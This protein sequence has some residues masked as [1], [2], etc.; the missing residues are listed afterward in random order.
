MKA[1]ALALAG[2]IDLRCG[3]VRDAPGCENDP[4]AI[5]LAR[6]AVDA[7]NKNA[8]GSCV[9]RWPHACQLEFEK[10]VKVKEQL[11][12]GT[13]YYFTIEAKDGE[14]KKLYEAKVYECPWRNLMEL[15][16]F[17]PADC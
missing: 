6:F 7:H 15:R 14:A 9:C 16:D 1:A 12:S 13:L 3:G 5:D 8:D 17:N 10:L 2:E 11:V 4:C